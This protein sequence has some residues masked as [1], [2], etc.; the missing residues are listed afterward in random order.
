MMDQPAFAD[1]EYLGKKPKTGRELFL[2]R[3]NGLIP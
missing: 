1:L 3:M 2:E